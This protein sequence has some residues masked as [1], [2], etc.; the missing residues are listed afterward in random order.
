MVAFAVD[1]A[2]ASGDPASSQRPAKDAQRFVRPD[3]FPCHPAIDTS[4]STGFDAP[5]LSSELLQQLTERRAQAAANALTLVTLANSGH[6]GGSLSSIDALMLIYQCANLDGKNPTDE[7]RD[8]VVVSH[9]HI[10]PGVYATLADAGYFDI[11]DAFDGFRRCGSAFGGH[12]EKEVP[13][14]EWNTGNLG[15]GLS[16]GAGFA[17]AA[18]ARDLDINVFVGMGDGEQQKGQLSEARRFAAHFN[19]SNLIAFVD[20]NGLQIGGKTSDIQ[21]QDHAAVWEADGWN[22]LEA[23]GHDFSQLYEVFRAAVRRETKNPDAPTV[24]LLRTVMGKGV[25][26]IE[27]LAKYHGSALSVEQL[28]DAYKELGVEDRYE[29]ILKHREEAVLPPAHFER[30][31]NVVLD[32]GEPITYAAGNVTDCRSAYGAALEDLAQRNVNNPDAW[33]IL[34]ISCDLEGSVKM[35]GFRKASGNRFIEAG[36]AEHNAAVVAGAASTMNT[37][38][39]FST[40]GMFA[41]VESYNQQRLNDQNA[42]APRV[43]VT[44]C[45]LDVGEDG[46]THQCIDYVS[47]AHNIFGFE[48]YAPADPN[49]TDRIVRYVAGNHQPSMVTMGRSKLPVISTPDGKPALAQEFVPGKWQ[50]LREGEDA[51]VFAFGTMVYRAVE[52]SDALKEDG[53]GLRVV[54]ASSLKPFD[55]DAIIDAA[56]FVGTLFT[57][58]D[59]NVHTGL[60]A[61]VA[62]VLGDE[63]IGAKLKRL[64]VSQY[65]TSGKPDELFAA[66]GL[67]PEDLVKAVK[68]AVEKD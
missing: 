9:G 22:V 5:E 60:G 40:F 47:I 42:A 52:A 50:T 11:Q 18:R 21:D 53:I 59:H 15:Q 46:P 29:E 62:G 16:A 45:G 48:L 64:G 33:P 10:S 24:L 49:E 44:H 51:V 39:F 66:Q 67:A 43:V 31:R 3:F 4:M 38:P 23:D 6:P 56:R 20:V 12:I 30:D 2:K 1:F 25:S 54:N 55:R 68:D 36:I 57:Y 34:G 27:D 28:K 61:I 19:L 17:I 37:V 35:Q 13:G 58:E 32:L 63:G 7:A 26:F 41:I 8:R 65:G 14:V